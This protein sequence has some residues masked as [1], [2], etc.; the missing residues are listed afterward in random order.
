[1]IPFV[2]V[3]GN[4]AN[5]APEHIAATAVNVGVV[6]VVSVTVTVAV[7]STVHGDVAACVYV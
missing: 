4:A 2:E 6:G 7:L 5:V 3:V 1:V